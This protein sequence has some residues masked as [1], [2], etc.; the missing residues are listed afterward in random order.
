MGLVL[1]GAEVGDDFGSWIVGVVSQVSQR[2]HDIGVDYEIRNKTLKI[3]LLAIGGPAFYH[4]QRALEL[5]SNAL[6][7]GVLRRAEARS[8]ATS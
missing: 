6:K 7:Q 2:L 5:L 3:G 1:E 4:L 8:E